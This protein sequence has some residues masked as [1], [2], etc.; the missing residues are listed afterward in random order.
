MIFTITVQTCG[1][2]V[3]QNKFGRANAEEFAELAF[4]CENVYSVEV[5]SAETGE[6]IYY[7]AKG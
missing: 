1:D 6:V 2:I 7:R 4:S 5:I 3:K